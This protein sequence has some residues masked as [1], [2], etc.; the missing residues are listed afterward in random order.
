VEHNTGYQSGERRLSLP[1]AFA[2]AASAVA[3]LG[4]TFELTPGLDASPGMWRCVLRKQNY[5]PASGVGMGKGNRAAAQTGAVFEALE[6]YLS[7]PDAV[8]DAAVTLRPVA[9]VTGSILARDIAVSLLTE[10]GDGGDSIGCWSFRAIATGA[11]LDVPVFLSLPDYL[12]DAGDDLRDRLGDRHDYAHVERYSC[13]NGWAAGSDRV[14]AAVHALNEVIERDALSL[15]LI[16]QFI[17]RGRPLRL[18][19]PTTLPAELGDLLARAGE[20]TGNQVYI[21]DMTTDLG[22]PSILAFRS[23]PSGQPARI[24]GCGTSLSMAYAIERALT[25]LVQAQVWAGQADEGSASV[26]YDQTIGYPTLHACRGADLT[27]RLA[28]AQVLAYAETDVPDAPVG[29]LDRLVEILSAHAFTPYLREH[30]VTGNI[31]VVNVIVPGLERFMLI[32][33]GCLVVPGERGRRR[34]VDIT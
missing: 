19:D 8:D 18:I 32:T 10:S 34:P 14:E 28:S 22:I 30:H 21:V 27:P 2:R 12:R 24:R 6:H 3:E 17:D 7:G 4:M 9:D 29:H 25:E 1:D 23:P 15:L 31:A 5:V 26:S 33:D 20:V 13:N 16:E 11:E